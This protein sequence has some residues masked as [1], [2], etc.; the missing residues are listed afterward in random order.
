FKHNVVWKLAHVYDNIKPKEQKHQKHKK[1]RSSKSIQIQVIVNSLGLD[2][3]YGQKKNYKQ[4]FVTWYGI[5]E[6]EVSLAS[7]SS[8]ATTKKDEVQTLEIN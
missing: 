6:T 8:L 3:K 7:G 1:F 5:F 2:Y 4:A